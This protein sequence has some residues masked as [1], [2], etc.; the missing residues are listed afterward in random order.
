MSGVG[1]DRLSGGGGNVLPGGP[2][3]GNGGGGAKKPQYSSYKLLVDPVLVKGASKL[4]RF[5]GNVPDDPCYPPVN[6][7]DPRS[8]LAMSRLWNRLEGLELPVPRFKIDS[9]YVGAPPPL[10]VTI[11]NINDNVDK[12]FLKEI[13]QKYGSMEEIFIYYHPVSKKHLGLGRIVF[14][15]RKAAKECVDKMNGRS[16]MGQVLEAFFDPF[17]AKC[18]SMY[19]ELTS[20]KPKPEPVKVE[21]KSSKSDTGFS[22]ETKIIPV[23]APSQSRND[24]NFGSSSQSTTGHNLSHQARSNYTPSDM[25]YTPTSDTSGAYSESVKT[26]VQF[27]P[28]SG[29]YDAYGAYNPHYQSVGHVGTPSYGSSQSWPVHPPTP[30]PPPPKSNR[31]SHTSSACENKPLDNGGFS[32]KMDLDTRIKLLLKGK[33]SNDFGKLFGLSD[34]ESE[35][36]LKTVRVSRKRSR[37]SISK[38]EIWGSESE[39]ETVEDK[40]AKKFKRNTFVP[41]EEPDTLNI[42]LPENNCPPS[43]SPPPSP[44]LSL[45]KPYNNGVKNS[46]L[47]NELDQISDDSEGLPGLESRNEEEMSLSSLSPDDPSTIRLPPQPQPPPPPPVERVSAPFT[48]YP[49]PPLPFYGAP[50]F[51]GRLPDHHLQYSSH[52]VFAPW[53]HDPVQNLHLHQQAQFFP[54]IPFPP[55]VP[56]P[57]P[58]PQAPVENQAEEKDSTSTIISTVL[59]H[60]VDELKQILR[61]DFQ[62]RMIEN[63]AYKSFETWWS[64]NEKLQKEQQA[65]KSTTSTSETKPEAPAF[66]WSASRFIETDKPTESNFSLG[67][68]ASIPKLPSFRRKMRTPSPAYMDDDSRRSDDSDLD[69]T[70]SSWDSRMPPR[71]RIVRNLSLSSDQSSSESSSSATSSDWDTDD[72]EASTLNSLESFSD[73]ELH[74]SDKE[75]SKPDI[76]DLLLETESISDESAHSLSQT[77]TPLRSVSPEVVAEKSI[78]ETEKVQTAVVVNGLKVEKILSAAAA[79]LEEE[80]NKEV[81]KVDDWQTGA[82]KAEVTT[83]LLDHSYCMK[84]PETPEGS[85][86]EEDVDVEDTVINTEAEILKEKDQLTTVPSVDDLGLLKDTLVVAKPPTKGSRKQAKT[87]KVRTESEELDITYEFLTKGIDAED[88]AYMKKSYEMMLAK[89]PENYWLNQTHWVDHAPTNI[90]SPKLRSDKRVHLTGS[91]RTEGFYKLDSAEKQKHKLHLSLATALNHSGSVNVAGMCQDKPAGKTQILSREARSNQRRLLTALGSEFESDLLKFNQLKFR[92]KNLRF[93]RSSI[94]DWGLFAAEP[95]AAD[96]MVIEY[97]G[98]TI[99]PIIADVRERKY[100][101]VGI[102]SSYLFRIDLENIIDATRC[103]NLSRFINHSCSPN[104]YAKI[105]TIEGQKKIVIYSKQ[106]IAVNE[107]ITYDYKFPFEEEKIVCLCGSSQCRR[108]LN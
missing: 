68:K 70:K 104:C 101:A 44:F 78:D 25:A 85:A 27:T 28:Y 59:D 5:D 99:R 106:Q 83:F 18:K 40:F 51:T 45:S 107:E 50:S 82:V 30:P 77:S 80:E 22:V 11:T 33:R 72:D 90:P 7:R 23:S 16:L 29:Q 8:S 81:E 3:N 20:E 36:E 74:F 66:S 79:A 15:L 95:I 84:E 55:M 102:G 10:E 53:H 12:Q 19:E 62:R 48:A 35:P 47:D 108:T 26:S 43:R 60:L 32:P 21:T 42:P 93:A 17:G 100:E 34:D 49:P 41:V 88:I 14:E 6:V 24:T 91:A 1:G 37:V 94:H 86:G 31:E 76:R 9:N 63:V 39:E 61:R 56:P 46:S 64:D 71:G 96:E 105:I 69:E 92:K 73:K 13:L 52:Y 4:Y 87:F 65:T 38:N 97:V 57:P 75:E 54:Q 89:D 103:G 2:G 98:Q 58:E 67:F